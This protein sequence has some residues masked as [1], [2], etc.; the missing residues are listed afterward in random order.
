MALFLFVYF[1]LHLVLRLWVRGGLELD[2]SELLVL[3][4]EWR[5]GYGSQPPLYVWLQNAF[6]FVLGHNILAV[7]LLKDLFLWTLFF[8][9][10]RTARFLSGQ[11]RSALVAML[12]L[13]LI[14]QIAWEG[15]RDLSHTL[16]VLT[17]TAATCGVGWGALQFGRAR[18]YLGLGLIAAL[19]LLSKYNYAL[20][21]AQFTLATLSLRECR[22]DLK[23]K[24]VWLS[25][26]VI[27][28]LIGPHLWWNLA[29]PGELFAQTHKLQIDRSRELGTALGESFSSLMMVLVGFLPLLLATY[30][31][32]FGNFFRVRSVGPATPLS[33]R[34]MGRMVA[35]GAIIC[36]ALVVV[37]QMRLKQ[38]WLL[39]VLLSVPF[40]GSMKIESR[41]SP[42]R[43]RVFCV[44]TVLLGFGYLAA[45]PLRPWI[46]A[47]FGR[48]SKLNVPYSDLADRLREA[49]FKEGV[50][51]AE[52][53]HV[54]GNLK[55]RF[56]SSRV[57]VPELVGLKVPEQVDG[58][59]VWDAR[60]QRNEPP[61]ELVELARARGFL[62]PENAP[63]QFLEAPFRHVPD[64]TMRLGLIRVRAGARVK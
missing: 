35:A 7:A 61:A 29:H 51:V 20:F 46:Q 19:G 26:G 47:Q 25:L 45:V 33:A 14:P 15:E 59:M 44:L 42:G 30:W 64:A 60:D 12:S 21:F 40:W 3:G 52:N 37:W 54:G 23:A 39:P 53:R 22:R 18:D 27:L 2:E 57:I 24:W 32:V 1:G 41:I 34:W 16:A 36:V 28:L 5:L 13:F 48:F 17:C 4:Q 43:L 31:I 50:I 6:F 58:I 55:L 9:V 10:F 8:L 38:R 49:G 11:E 56:P 62:F 63:P